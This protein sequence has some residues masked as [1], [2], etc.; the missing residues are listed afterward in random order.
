MPRLPVRLRGTWAESALRNYS[1]EA[2]PKRLLKILDD[3]VAFSRNRNVPVFCGEY[4]VYIPNSPPE[5]RVIWYEFVTNALDR[6]N[7]SRT[8]WDYHG[9]FGIFNFN[10]RG[11]FNHDVNTAVVKAMG[12][13]PPLQ[14]PRNNEPLRTGFVIFD[15]FP[16]R[17]ITAGFWG[18]D[19][20]DFSFYDTN[21][22]DGEFAVRWSNTNRYSAFWFAFPRNGNF[23]E[24]VRNGFF[25]EFKARTIRPARFDIRFIMN[26]D[27][28]TIPWR[29]IFTINENN[30]P[31]DG[32]WHT[33]R[34]PLGSM[35]EQGAWINSTSEWL[36][37]RG[38][39]SWDR[40]NRLEFGAEHM[41]LTGISIWFDSIR[42][43][44]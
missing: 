38:E 21:A 19:E 10:G 43:T 5:D 3:V 35:T 34:I 40:I 23:T 11:D 13:N 16:G 2:S 17:E 8:S 15:D 12:F 28:S 32:R 36:D 30:L 39:F 14:I 24:L 29:K 33:I 26:E 44:R 22:A 37:Q 27:S 20:T 4:G 42:I 31:A 6:R 25:L 7:I 1:Q 41:D 9:G 18:N